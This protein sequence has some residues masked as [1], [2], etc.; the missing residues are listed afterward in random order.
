MYRPVSIG[1]DPDAGLVGELLRK[2]VGTQID[3][4]EHLQIF[5]GHIPNFEYL[6]VKES[7]LNSDK[8]K[9]IFHATDFKNG[10][11]VRLDI[12]ALTLLPLEMTRFESGK[13]RYYVQWQ[14]YKKIGSIDWPH[15]ITLKFPE[16]QE[17]L[18]IK[19]KDPTLNG[20]ISPEAFQL[21]SKSSE[22]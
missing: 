11:D 10:G 17:I 8:S 12:D 14:D 4:K 21:I 19:Y 1:P 5:V 15:L 16:R 18:K 7:R 13:K 2:L 20:E 3:F 9:Y 22:K 6:K